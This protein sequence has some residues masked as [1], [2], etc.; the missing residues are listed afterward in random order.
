MIF[1]NAFNHPKTSVAGSLIAVVTVAGVLGTQGVTLGHAGTGTIVTLVAAVATALLGLLARDPGAV[2]PGPVGPAPVSPVRVGTMPIDPANSTQKLGA[3]MLCVLMLSGLMAATVAMTGCTQAQK[4]SVAQEIVNWTPTFIST[5][6]TVSGLVEALDPATVVVLLPFTT[7]INV[8]GPQ[9]ELAARNYLAN[10]SQTTLQVLQALIVQIQQNTN[11]AVLAAVKITNPAV[12]AAATR[13]V[14][15]IA[16]V[17]NTLLALIQSIS[18]K[19][20]LVAMAS[21]VRVTV[22]EVRPYLDRGAMELMSAKVS[23][24]LGLARAV[25]SADFFAYEAAQGF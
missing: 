13:D 1:G 4:V 7:A 22:A 10:P 5:A 9:F 14:N 2:A 3:L 24:D 12:Q 21:H 25:T 6:D 18:T 8:F 23:R 15:L 16:T 11:A 19:T 20:Q 17:V